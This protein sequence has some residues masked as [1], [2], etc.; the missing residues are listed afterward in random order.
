MFII[1]YGFSQFWETFDTLGVWWFFREPYWCSILALTLN[2]S[3]Y[4]SEII[5]GGLQS[6]PQNQIV[7]AKAFGMSPFLVYRRIILPLALRHAIPAYGNEIILI[8]KGTSLTSIITLVEITK[9]AH[10]IISQTYR[11]SEVFICA[12]LI[13]LTINFIIISLVTVLEYLLSPQSRSTS[14]S[15]YTK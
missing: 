1:Y 12:S 6:V 3:A 10:E 4:G 15:G 5:R 8:V 13:Y 14:A 9:I 2:T 7:A 11:T